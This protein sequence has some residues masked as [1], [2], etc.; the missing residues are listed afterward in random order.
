M[1]A[2]D[3]LLFSN[4][5]LTRRIFYH[6]SSKDLNNCALVNKTLHASVQ[7]AR[8]NRNL[9]IS[10]DVVRQIYSNKGSNLD[11]YLGENYTFA[12]NVI[13]HGW[14]PKDRVTE[15][16]YDSLF[17]ARLKARNLTL[18]GRGSWLSCKCPR[19]G[20]FFGE[21]IDSID[22]DDITKLES[23]TVTPTFRISACALLDLVS[24]SPKL[25]ILRFFGLLEKC[26]H[27]ELFSLKR[28]LCDLERLDWPMVIKSHVPTV[29]T[30][31]KRNEN[32]TFFYSCG[33]LT[34]DLLATDCLSNLRYL[35]LILNE[36]WVD[37]PAEDGSIKKYTKRAQRYTTKI[38]YIGMGKKIEGL[39]VRTF[40]IP[41]DDEPDN[42][43][44][45]RLKIE[46]LH[47][48][49]KLIFWEQVA[50][51]PCL[52]YLSVNGAWELNE[53][54][55]E[56]AKHD[57]KIEFLKIALLPASL[58]AAVSNQ[59]DSPTLSMVDEA[60][61]LRK[62]PKL[63][64]LWFSCYEKLGSIDEK[65]AHVLRD[66]MDLIW[67]MD[68][69]VMFTEEVESLLNII[70][71]RGNQLGKTY[72]V[73]LHVQPR[74]EKLTNILTEH[75]LKFQLGTELKQKLSQI[76]ENELSERHGTVEGFQIWGL[77]Q[78]DNSR[79]KLTFEQF[80]NIWSNY[81][82]MFNLTSPWRK[83]T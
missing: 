73:V 75:N 25:K 62:L 24:R 5:D 28:F 45:L 23:I 37:V 55:R 32:I 83:L 41:F 21:Q 59:E 20:S 11:T 70:M 15:K 31:V 46:P 54:C 29:T 14:A 22:E 49:Y 40:D 12:P 4:Y 60:R 56:L 8:E 79:D 9:R 44:D 19:K 33:E 71:R 67:T 69:K 34:C 16:T 6:L 38:K 10:A 13:V 7:D 77:Q 18:K 1:I 61:N 39:E 3:Y 50:K 64:S 72:K 17:K 51:L 68:I 53:V 2:P 74:E 26:D 36:K 63:R 30:L 65:T 80:K 27:T 82:S 42:P 78:I 48:Q 81:D 43:S 47:E 35:S 76:A 57:S 52:K 66:L 58:Q